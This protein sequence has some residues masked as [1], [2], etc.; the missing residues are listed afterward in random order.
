MN[1]PRRASTMASGLVV[2]VA[3]SVVLAAA[4]PPR[5]DA[6]DWPSAVERELPTADGP[7]LVRFGFARAAM[8]PGDV[9]ELVLEIE[10]PGSVPARPALRADG[11]I[12]VPGLGP[13]PGVDAT[14]AGDDGVGDATAGDPV[15]GDGATG[16][17]GVA[18]GPA[19]LDVVD[20]T[21]A[22]ELP[23]TGGDPRRRLVRRWQVSTFRPGSAVIGP[24]VVLVGDE[25]PGAQPVPVGPIRIEVASVVA[26]AS[27]PPDGAN[28]LAPP[29]V[30]DVVAIDDRGGVVLP[31]AVI[32][33]I[34]LVVVAAALLL[35]RRRA[36]VPAPTPVERARGALDRLDARLAAD[37]ADLD[38]AAWCDDLARAVRTAVESGPGALAPGTTVQD[39]VP[40]R[41]VGARLPAA[42][43]EELAVVLEACDR[44]RFAGPGAEVPPPAALLDG[45][46]R[47]VDAVAELEATELGR[48]APSPGPRAARPAEVRS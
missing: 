22:P 33:T 17:G 12:D 13:V 6:A 19:A 36:P 26:E 11:T 24:L 31:A 37:G 1:V 32:G 8:R 30:A 18:P 15:S 29:D 5:E 3:A 2:A 44:V 47:V 4:P 16:T 43:I 40:R 10:R 46:R 41:P 48:P 25:G 14:D 38:R 34:A 35:V 20:R 45:A 9:V 39:L 7:I 23:V 21:V 27:S 42:V 28:P